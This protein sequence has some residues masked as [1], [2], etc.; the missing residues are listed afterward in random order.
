[1]YK[2][3]I[4]TSS[5]R[6]PLLPKTDNPAFQSANTEVENIL[7]DNSP[8]GEGGTKRK[9]GNYNNYSPEVRA[10]MAKYAIE[11]G[12]QYTARKFTTDLGSP[13]DGPG[14]GLEIQV[15]PGRE[16]FNFIILKVKAHQTQIPDESFNKLKKDHS[17]LD[18]SFEELETEFNGLTGEVMSDVLALCGKEP[19]IE[20]ARCLVHFTITQANLVGAPR[21]KTLAPKA[22]PD[23]SASTSSGAVGGN[24]P[25][26]DPSTT[27]D[28]VPL[29]NKSNDIESRLKDMENKMTSFSNKSAESQVGESLA[30]VRILASRPNLTPSHVLLAAIESLV[31]VATKYGHKDAEF[32]SKA[33]TYCKKFEVSK[34]ICNLAMKLFGSAEDKKLANM[35]AEWMKG[36]KY[37]ASPK[38]SVRIEQPDK[39][40]DIKMPHNFGAIDNPA[41]FGYPFVQGPMPMPPFYGSQGYSNF[42]GNFGNGRF[43]R[44]GRGGN[45]EKDKEDY[46]DYRGA[47]SQS[48][49]HI[50]AEGHFK[51]N[52]KGRHY[53]H[54]I[55]PG[56]L[57]PNAK[58]C[59]D[60]TQFIAETLEERLRNGSLTLLGK[61]GECDPPY[62]VL[63]LTIEPSKPR[64]CHDE[65]YLNFWIIDSPFS[66]ETLRD[67]PRLVRKCDLMSSLDDKS[68]YDH[69]FLDEN[70]R[71]YFGLQFGGYYF[72][73]NT[74]PF[75]FK[76]S[77]Y[78]YQMTGLTATGFC[79]SLGV[80]CL[81]NID[82]R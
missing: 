40:N 74:I 53:D 63:P 3:L 70:S 9:R 76:A 35:V 17:L 22:V 62:L 28:F 64:L 27:P 39:E 2:F 29:G 31:T 6:P 73:F 36:K 15:F 34:D 30:H 79:R 65:R 44:R 13:E 33:Y 37:E 71:K 80:P 7:V 12:V 57:L 18:Y 54:N 10:K 46:I 1:M 47:I 14:T 45:T 69:I 60:Y 41:S 56:I 50:S 26:P 52:F 19:L 48:L 38:K 5:P 8:V 78:I 16:I 43:N 59:E 55:P 25:V 32:F 68:G 21:G 82:D 24:I 49:T 75:G 20:N 42:Q 51:G 66:L 61:V 67:L 58:I 4:K 81:Q 23:P 72:V 11:N 77:A